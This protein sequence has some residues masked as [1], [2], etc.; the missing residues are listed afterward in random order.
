MSA[1]LMIFNLIRDDQLIEEGVIE[2]VG[3]SVFEMTEYVSEELSARFGIID[4]EFIDVSDTWWFSGLIDEKTVTLEF[5]PIGTPADK[6][7]V[8]D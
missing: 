6:F 4:I 7:G 5:A 8:G 1:E 2:A 3:D